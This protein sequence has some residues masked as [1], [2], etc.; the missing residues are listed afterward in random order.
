MS[1]P[2]LV[3]V[4]QVEAALGRDLTTEEAARIDFLLSSASSRIRAYTRQDFTFVEDD[5]AVLR[6]VG[7][8]IRLPQLP[9]TEV[10]NVVAIGLGGLPDVTLGGWSWDGISKV[11]IRGIGSVV[12]NLPEWWYSYGPD[13]YRV[14]YS[15]GYATIPQDVVDAAINMILRVL[16]SPSPVEGMVNEKIG[17]YGY[18]MQQGSGAAGA[19]IAMNSSDK[20]L[21]SSYRRKAGTIEI[22]VLG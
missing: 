10:T 8:V 4:E 1:L 16:Y 5:E 19:S 14:T 7:T 22:G 2:P 12:L 6:P 21:L 3:S 15:H 18:Q 20:E 11:D 17:Q 9:V 13:T